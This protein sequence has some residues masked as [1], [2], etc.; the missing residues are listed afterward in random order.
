MQAVGECVLTTTP[1]ELLG[2]DSPELRDLG[3]LDCPM[4]VCTTEDEASQTYTVQLDTP[5]LDLPRFVGLLNTVA[6]SPIT[7]SAYGIAADW[8]IALLPN[9]DLFEKHARLG[10]PWKEFIP[11][12][13]PLLDIVNSDSEPWLSTVNMDKYD[14]WLAS[15]PEP[16]HMDHE[17]LQQAV[18]MDTTELLTELADLGFK[19]AQAALL[20]II[21]ML[22][23]DS[24]Y[25]SP[26]RYVGTTIAETREKMRRV[27]RFK[28]TYQQIMAFSKLAVD[29]RALAQ[30]NLLSYITSD[31]SYIPPYYSGYCSVI[32]VISPAFSQ[33]IP[34]YNNVKDRLGRPSIVEYFNSIGFDIPV[35][36]RLIE[37]A[38]IETVDHPNGCYQAD[39]LTCRMGR[40]YVSGEPMQKVFLDYRTIRQT[41]AVTVEPQITWTDWRDASG[42]QRTRWHLETAQRAE[43]QHGIPTTIHRNG[44]VGLVAV[45]GYST[46]VSNNT[47]V[48]EQQLGLPKSETG[49]KQAMGA[50][51][52]P[53]LSL[54]YKHKLGQANFTS[55]V[56][57]A[58]GA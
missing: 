58:T 24:F 33:S 7:Q 51:Q 29:N 54:M 4:A 13:T 28:N 57:E 5:P 10:K 20:S 42:R 16:V 36:Y 50:A 11:H 18:T 41:R 6:T 52:L 44:L 8:Q 37:E 21:E 43:V 47:N 12:A 34:R 39:A 45:A 49:R 40:N 14:E 38:S 15:L 46:D 32:H 17:W 55:K 30:G 48:W 56:R 2:L 19:G 35:D 53:L 22:A 1:E 23:K 26:D 9:S 31:N 25:S 27:M 3:M